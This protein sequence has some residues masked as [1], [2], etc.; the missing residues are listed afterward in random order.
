MKK[1]MMSLLLFGMMVFLVGATLAE[2]RLVHEITLDNVYDVVLNKTG[3]AMAIQSATTN[4]YRL[5]DPHGNALT[6]EIYQEMHGEGTAFSFTTTGECFGLMNSA[7]QVIVPE[8]YEKVGSVSPRWSYGIHGAETTSDTYDFDVTN[9]STWESTKYILVDVDIYYQGK[10]VGTV[11]REDWVEYS[12]Y[13]YG[14]YLY[15]AD[16]TWN[17]HYYNKDFVKSSVSG[18]SSSEYSYDYFSGQITHCGSG[19]IAFDSS[20]TLSADEVDL[21]YYPVGKTV[22]DLQGNALFQMDYDAYA[23]TN[24][25]VFVRDENTGKFGVIDMQGN[26]CVPIEYDNID[27]Y[28]NEFPFGIFQAEKDGKLGYVN[29]YG[30][31]TAEFKYAASAANSQGLFSYLTDLDGSIILIGAGCGEFGEHFKEV[32][33]A[34]SDSMPLAAVKSMDDEYAVVDM[35]GNLVI[36]Y[37]MDVDYSVYDIECSEDGRLVVCQNSNYGTY[38]IYQIEHLY[39]A[40]PERS[41]VQE[42]RTEPVATEVPAQNQEKDETIVEP[43]STVGTT[44]NQKICLRG[45]PVIDGVVLIE[46]DK[47]EEVQITGSVISAK[48]GNRWYVAQYQDYSG[49]IFCKNLT[50]SSTLK[51]ICPNC[52]TVNSGKFCTECGTGHECNVCH[53]IAYGQVGKFCP[54]CGTKFEE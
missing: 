37:P 16:P 3:D 24:E 13:A 15:M 47:N 27:Y 53:Y 42:E 9:F 5:V 8:E 30:V 1:A 54:E 29:R 6:D 7:G 25:Y 45:E 2:S 23:I 28:S 11:D 51:W 36:P 40:E 32:H 43:I 20:C 14:D 4:L 49:Y 10:K 52:Q 31:E 46:L 44:I 34:L 22:Y 19:Q 35:E 33:I 12:I 50:V 18:V 17:W 21:R 38:T 39:S 41:A 48:S 26:I